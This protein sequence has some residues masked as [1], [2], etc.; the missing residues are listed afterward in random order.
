MRRWS[1]CWANDTIRE[2]VCCIV[3]YF[4]SG[5]RLL[6]MQKIRYHNA[7]RYV[8]FTSLP[9]RRCEPALVCATMLA[10]FSACLD[11]DDVCQACQ[12]RDDVSNK[13]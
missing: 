5:L 2:L 11:G 12:R 9:L 10:D 3:F 7:F 4:A 6:A 1:S 13:D 8:C